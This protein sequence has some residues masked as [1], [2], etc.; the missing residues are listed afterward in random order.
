[1]KYDSQKH[2]RTFDAAQDRQSIRLPD[3]DYSQPGAYF[4]T[5]VTHGRERLF[6]EVKEG[7]MQ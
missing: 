4:I 5:I 2:H 6:G 7:E 1:M 3:Y